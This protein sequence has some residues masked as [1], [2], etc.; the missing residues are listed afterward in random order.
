MVDGV[1]GDVDVTVAVNIIDRRYTEIC[2]MIGC[3]LMCVSCARAAAS[4]HPKTHDTHAARKTS[5]T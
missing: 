1:V 4:P 2:V 5:T 3:E